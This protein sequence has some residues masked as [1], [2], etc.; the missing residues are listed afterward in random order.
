MQVDK[1]IHMQVDKSYI[2]MQVDKSS[3]IV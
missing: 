3:L 1:S 2:H